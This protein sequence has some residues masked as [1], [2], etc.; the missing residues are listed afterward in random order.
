[1]ETLNSIITLQD[2]HELVLRCC[3]TSAEI[4]SY[5]V[6]RI[7][8]AISGFLGEH[9]YLIVTLRNGN[10]KRFFLK[11]LPILKGTVIPGGHYFSQ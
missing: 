5:Q 3:H 6:S 7:G 1:M 8:G 9:L 4:D 10:S 2:C 11:T